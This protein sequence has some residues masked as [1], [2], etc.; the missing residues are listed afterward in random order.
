MIFW[1]QHVASPSDRCC[2]CSMYSCVAYT[3]AATVDWV[4]YSYAIIDY[5]AMCKIFYDNLVIVS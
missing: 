2:Y 1:K 4:K 5:F 3:W